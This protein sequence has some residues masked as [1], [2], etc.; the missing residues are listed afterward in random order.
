MH[1]IIFIFIFIFIYYREA[2]S[3]FDIE[4]KNYDLLFRIV[5]RK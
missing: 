5:R 3:G 1:F 2:R 4:E